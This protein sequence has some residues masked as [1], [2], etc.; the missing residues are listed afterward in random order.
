[1]RL[2]AYLSASRHGIFYF[3]YPLPTASHP[4]RKRG[5]VKVSLATR[6]PRQAGQL[7]R[8]LAV[9]GQSVL[10]RPKVRAMRYDEMRQHVRDHFGQL[11]RQ[12]RE[13]SA[14]D[15][16]ATDLDLDA[17]SASLGLAEG[18]PD[19]WASLSHADGTDGLLR[20]F[21]DVRGI[22]P[23]PEGRARALMVTELQ[24]G[25]REYVTRALEHTAEFNTLTLEQEVRPA[26]PVAP[27][28]ASKPATETKLLP[29]ADV[30]ARYFAELERT[31]ALAAKTDGEKRDALALMSKLTGDKPPADMR[32]ADAQEVKAAL[33]KLPK[34]RSK[35]P[36]TRDLPLLDMLEVPGIERIAARTMNVYLGHMQH[37]FGWAVDNGYAADNVFR[38]LRLKRT[39]RSDDEGRKAF[40]GDQL[41]LMF[42]HLTDPDSPLVRKDVHKWPALIGDPPPMKWS[43]V[44]FRK[45]EDQNGY[46]AAQAGRDCHEAAAG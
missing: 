3:R 25:Y 33:F 10:A 43:A 4:A 5:H 17:L 41:R 26:P 21:C 22:A 18:D 14:V 37:F 1:M 24:K 38:G 32:K 13:R 42:S 2:A 8:L 40:S 20:A 6:E 44:M 16:P 28:K 7:A 12:F 9:A 30:L 39:A 36:K 19:G 46:E 35:N 31:K 27:A 11:L 15:G 23:E 34:N 29:F 45:T